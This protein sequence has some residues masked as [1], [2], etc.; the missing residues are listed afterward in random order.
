MCGEFAIIATMLRRSI[1]ACLLVFGCGGTPSAKS[2]EGGELSED[3]ASAS[4]EATPQG[5]E[6]SEKPAPAAEKAAAAPASADDARAVLQLVIDDEALEPYLHLDKPDRFPLRIGGSVL[7]SGLELTK[8]T[9]PVIIVAEVGAEKKPIIVFSELSIEGDEASVR[10]R[11]DVE[12]LRGSATL[13]RREGHWVLK[14]SR[15][16]EH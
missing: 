13:Q 16:T 4:A 12:K 2:P 9:K 11:Y 3:S 5:E 10:Y 1:I 8:A 14:R 15:V 7:P 6:A